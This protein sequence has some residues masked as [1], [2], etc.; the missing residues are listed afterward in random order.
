MT[1]TKDDKVRQEILEQ[2]QLL[3]QRYGL[4]K[5][6]MDEI[7]EACN[8]AKSTLYHYFT[9]K[10]EVFDEVIKM[11]MKSL[12]QIVRQKVDGEK[13]IKNK[14]TQYFATYHQEILN[15][16]NIYRIAK[17]ELK[18]EEHSRKYFMMMMDFETRYLTRILEDGYDAGDFKELDRSDIPWFAETMLASF[19]GI[20]RYSIEKDKAF[21][22][23]KLNK[24]TELIIPKFFN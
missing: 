10:N 1:A 5:T 14:F 19:F 13:G 20:V 9:S 7:A 2:A 4:K 3:F 17:Q 16:F 21:D 6:T 15:K 24:A 23:G 18:N 12:R 8:K 22:L 11:E